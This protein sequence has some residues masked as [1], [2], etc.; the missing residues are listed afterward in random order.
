MKTLA[1]FVLVL[2]ISVASLVAAALAPLS[3]L[4]F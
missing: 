1:L 4:P 2:A 3:N